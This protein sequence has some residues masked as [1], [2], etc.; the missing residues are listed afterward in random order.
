M[1]MEMNVTGRGRPARELSIDRPLA[2]DGPEI[3][4]KLDDTPQARRRWDAF[5]DTAP[6]AT[7]F[8]RAGWREVIEKSFGHRM[9]YFYAERGGETVGV[10]PLTEIRSLLFGHALISNAFSVCGGPV[11]VDEPAR[12]ALNAS[13]LTLFHATGA[14]HLEY[15]AT[16]KPKP[17][18]QTR[19]NL[20]AAFSGP[21]PADEAENLKQIPRKQRAVVRKAIESKLTYKV[22]HDVAALY[23][24]Y[25]LSVRNL[26][27]PVF[28]KRY[29]QNLVATF[30]PDCDVLTVSHDGAPIASVMNFY[31]RDRVMP[32]YTGSRPEARRL[33]A[34]DLMY[35]RLMRHAAAR[36]ARVFDF[37][38]S[39]VGTGPFE[40]KKNWGFTPEPIAHHFLTRD[41]AP[42]P[43]LNPLNPKFQLMIKTWK[44]LPLAI[45]NRLGPLIVRNI[46]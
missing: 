46:G 31:F 29:F 43:D 15:R 6:E 4:K 8:H 18:W 38:R 2:Q 37:G 36:G 25:A 30:A 33:G 19:D 35:W 10:L 12:G 14:R 17:E 26:G 20:Y 21:L 39:K 42:L 32:F 24:L 3:V 23:D 27:T 22:G 13:A 34:N 1:G 45:A 16:I 11:A 28:P 5:V 7:F 9:H 41:N 40:F 44:R